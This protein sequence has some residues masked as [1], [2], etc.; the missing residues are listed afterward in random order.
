MTS[1]DLATTPPG[2]LST[3]RAILA[4][5][6]KSFALAARLL[7]PP[8]RDEVAVLYAWCRRAD[9]AVD[10][11]P[12]A[13]QPRALGRLRREL[14]DVYGVGVPA[15]ELPAA[16][17]AVVRQ[18][19]IPPE[20]P[21]ELLAGL[22]MDALGTRYPSVEALLGYCFRVAGTVGLMMCHVMGVADP[23]ALR[24]A[25]HLGMAMQLTNICRD[26][27]EDWER[28]RL[29]LPDALLDSCGAPGLSGALGGPLP[30]EAAPA[31]ARAVT[32]LLDE[33]ERLYA[34]GD[35]GT[36]ALSWRSALAV[37]A[38][39][40]VYAAI[41]ARLR[42][43]GCDVLAGRAVVPSLDKLVLAAG[44]G[45]ATLAELPR[46]LSHGF[47]RAPLERH[48]TRFPDDILPL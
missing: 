28:G 18:R 24:H 20:Y 38:A 33:A 30:R 48:V 5:H 17:A 11:A 46:R 23:R 14:A 25:A 34:S 13:E 12:R 15:G 41:G 32:R 40:R 39:R 8:V 3:C 22:E 19:G 4:R 27:V 45:A 6:S 44:A 35:A 7:P 26:V 47:E 43:R 2:A 21:G 1:D 10:L 16:L 37:R 9:D 29:Y 36:P 42:G 31:L